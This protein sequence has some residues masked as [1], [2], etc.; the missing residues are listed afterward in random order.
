MRGRT[1]A[2]TLSIL[3][4]PSSGHAKWWVENE[5]KEK[6]KR[7]MRTWKNQVPSL[8]DTGGLA[9]EGRDSSTR[10]VHTHSLFQQVA[11]WASQR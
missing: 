2:G 4:R 8:K 6:Q 10:P 7:T 1:S 11:M 9:E 5:E 3:A